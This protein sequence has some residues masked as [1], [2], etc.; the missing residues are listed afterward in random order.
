RH[1]RRDGQTIE[2]EVASEPFEFNGR[3]GRLV[4]ARDV[5]ERVRAQAAL[6]DSERR[7]RTIVEAATEGIWM[8]DAQTLTTFVNPAMVRMLG[9]EVAQMLGRSLFDFVPAERVAALEADIAKRQQGIA[10]RRQLRFA[11]RDGHIVCAEVS[12]APLLDDT[13]AYAGSLAMITDVS[14][15]IEAVAREARRS[16]VLALVAGGAPLTQVLE[17][18]VS[19][20]EASLP[21]ALGCVMLVDRSGRRLRFGAAPSL[22]AEY[23]QALEGL[24]VAEGEGACGGAAA[25]GERV[26]CEDLV[27]DPRWQATRSLVRRFGLAACWSEPIASRA[28]AVLGTLGMYRRQP[29]RPGDD[30]IASVGAAAKMA[31]IAIEYQLTAEALRESQ[32]MESLGTLAGGIA[33]DFNNILGAILSNL[34]LLQEAGA[35]DHDAP[36]RLAQIQRSAERARGLVQQILSFSRR[37]PTTLRAQALRPLVE[38][39]AS[40]LRATLPAGAHIELALSDE[41]LII[42]ADANQIQQVLMNLCSNAWHALRQQSGVIRIGLDSEKQRLPRDVTSTPGPQAHLWVRDDGAGMDE[43]TRSRIFEPFFTTKPVGVGTGLGLSVVHGIVNEHGGAIVVDSAPGRGST[44]HLYFPAVQAA[45]PTAFEAQHPP[46][47]TPGEGQRIL[48]VDDDE[49]MLLAD[50]ALLQAMGYRV[51]CRS[52]GRDAVAA[53]RAAPEAFDLLLVDFNMPE[54]SGLDV[55][56][57]IVAIRPDLPVI[58]GSG[59]ITD[60]LRA[61]AAALGV[62]A[63]V[64]KENT[65]EELGPLVQQVLAQASAVAGPPQGGRSPLGGQRTK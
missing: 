18:I 25:T 9:F 5:T 45:E 65:A 50:E 38:E 42:R 15:R 33:H 13:G 8:T 59:F 40:L 43:A 7:Y 27:A 22:P 4:M 53:V 35:A 29:H 3:P 49:V 60:E 26:I 56:R 48:C 46:S 21:G 17:T 39:A 20:L 44:F 61:Q 54:L 31:A 58:I 64:R 23:G 51:T 37:Q 12:A 41:P 28:G 10:D 36:A 57:Q 52:H 30:E 11:H 55:A 34:S 62:R 14:D 16:E 6:R 47:F 24:P 63:L 32:K 1:R 19:A 2:L